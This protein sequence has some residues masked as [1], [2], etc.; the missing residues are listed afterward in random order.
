[1]VTVEFEVGLDGFEYFLHHFDKLLL[2][3]GWVHFD[4]LLLCLLGD[5]VGFLVLEVFYLLFEVIHG[6]W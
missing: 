5:F 2:D 4:D 1:M 6:G 3:F